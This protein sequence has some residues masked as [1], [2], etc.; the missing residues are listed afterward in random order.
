MGQDVLTVLSA[1]NDGPSEVPQSE[2]ASS[3][4]SPG[5]A[6]SQA[7]A[8]A[9]ARGV[10]AR[11]AANSAVGTAATRAAR[12]ISVKLGYEEIVF[13]RMRLRRR[14]VGRRTCAIGRQSCV[15]LQTS[16]DPTARCTPTALVGSQEQHAI[17]CSWSRLHPRG[18]SGAVWLRPIL[19]GLALLPHALRWNSWKHRQS[20]CWH[21]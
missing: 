1:G 9:G 16:E 6:G 20:W 14:S 10:V 4:A 3:G 8:T 7:N 11:L 18:P 15:L 2:T 21:L 19:V 5:Q 13:P 12:G 17:P